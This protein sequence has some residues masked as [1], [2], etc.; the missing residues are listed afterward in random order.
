MKTLRF[1]IHTKS[2]EPKAGWIEQHTIAPDRHLMFAQASDVAFTPH[3][4]RAVGRVLSGGSRTSFSTGRLRVTKL[5]LGS[6][7]EEDSTESH[8]HPVADDG[9]ITNCRE[10]QTYE[11]FMIEVYNHL[12][13]PVIARPVVIGSSVGAAGASKA[14]I[15]FLIAPAPLG[16]TTAI[17]RLL[18]PAHGDLSVSM[19]PPCACRLQRITTRSDSEL[20]VTITDF[21]I[22]NVSLTLGGNHP[23]EFFYE[24]VDLRSFAMSPANKMIVC[25]SNTGGKPRWV[26]I[27]VGVGPINP[28]ESTS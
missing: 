4:A 26:E 23:V 2:G 8:A 21:R 27:D 12:R 17:H 24:G 18:V 15:D 25:L 11:T 10:I 6:V 7:A 9:T 5:W 14:E 20:D 1:Q 22:S 19:S 16:P 28:S 13:D 3:T